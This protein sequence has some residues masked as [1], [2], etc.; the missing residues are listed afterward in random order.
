MLPST[1]VWALL[2]DPLEGAAAG[3]GQ[4]PAALI[5][6]AKLP[7]RNVLLSSHPP[8]PH[9]EP[10]TG[11]LVIFKVFAK[12]MSKN[13]TLFTLQFWDTQAS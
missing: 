2:Q 12:L 3:E 11:M 5:A 4:A 8:H 9:P 7:F 10:H 6:V 13:E 1:W